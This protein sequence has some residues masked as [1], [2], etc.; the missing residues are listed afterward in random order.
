MLVT[1][2]IKHH[3]PVG[4]AKTAQRS[5]TMEEWTTLRPYSS[6][7]LLSLIADDLGVPFGLASGNGEASGTTSE[8]FAAMRK[9]FGKPNV[10]AVS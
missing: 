2:N 5:I 9:D 8:R 10:E 1:I 7:E 4:R 6:H 3:R